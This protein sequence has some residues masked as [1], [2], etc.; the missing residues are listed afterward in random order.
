MKIISKILKKSLAAVFIAAM[1][2]VSF[3]SILIPKTEAANSYIDGNLLFIINSSNEAEIARSVSKGVSSI[4]IPNY[5]YSKSNKQYY[6]VTRIWDNAFSDCPEL[7][8]I[9]ISDSVTSIGSN[10]FYNTAYYNNYTNWENGVLYISKHLIKA[11]NGISGTYAIKSGTKCIAD[12]AFKDCT[13]LKYVV[14]PSSVTSIG[15]SA[16]SGCTGLTS[17]TIGNSVTSIGTSA[18]SGCTGLT[19]ITIPNSVTSIGTS[20]FY[21]CTGLTSITIGNSVTS[22]GTYAFY[23]CTGL[24]SITIPNS[25]T[26][27]GTSAFSGCTGLT[28]ITIPNSVTS[29]GS[30][31]FEGCTGLTSITIPDSVTRIEYDAFSGC[32]GLTS[33]TIPD[34]V[35]S[36]GYRV[37]DGC[38]IKELIIADGSKTVTS[39]MVV[40][41]S[42]LEKVTIPDSVMS[43]E[44]NA[45]KDCTGFTSITIPDSV[46]GIGSSAFEGCT[47]LASIAIP[48]SVTNIGSNAFYNTAYYNDDANWENDVLYISNHLIKA[49]DSINGVYAIKYGTKCIADSAFS[50]CTLLTGITIPDS[51]ASIGDNA[52]KGCTDLTSIIIPDKA[53][54]GSNAFY[55][56]PAY[57]TTGN[58]TWTLDGTVLTISGNGSMANY[59]YNEK[60]SWRQDITKV[61]IKSGVKNIGNYA[62]YGCK[63][64]TSVIVPESVTTIGFSSFL[65]CTGLTSIIIPSSVT[66]IDSS[67]FSGCDKSKLIIYTDSRDATAYKYAKDNGYRCVVLLN[68]NDEIGFSI[69]GNTLTVIGTGKTPDYNLFTSTPWYSAKDSITRVIVDSRITEVGTY[70]FYG[71]DNLKEL[72]CENANLKLG[73]RAINTDNKN[74]RV[75][76]LSGGSLEEYCSD[77]SVNFVSPL[78]APILVSVT[79]NSITVKA[80]D[81]VN[82]EFSLNGVNWQRSGQFNSLQPVTEYK[83]YS[84]R[85]NE[86]SPI[87]SEPLVV[88]TTKSTVSAPGAPTIEE[89]SVNKVTLKAT[90]GYEYSCDGGLT[91]QSSNVFEGIAQ[92]KIYEFRIRKAE[93]ETIFASKKSAALYFALPKAPEIERIGA[94]TLTLKA[95]DGFEYSLD[96]IEWQTSPHFTGLINN[97]T[98]TVY[99]RISGSQYSNSYQLISSGTDVCINGTDKTTPAKP[100]API[101]ASKTSSS[102]T[103]KA[104]EGYEY[105][106]DVKVWQISNVFNGLNDDTE[107]TFYQRVAETETS[108]ASECSA[109]LKVKTDKAYT[110]GEL[111]GDGKITDKD[112][113]YLLMHCYFPG[114]YPVDQPCDYNGDGIINDKDAVYLLMH[115]YFPNDYPITK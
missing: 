61:I 21:G 108:Y 13:E 24:T 28:S 84:R 22:I 97:M 7:A 102:V 110:A 32:T 95:V 78:D 115:C 76:S 5:V 56:C 80:A 53:T 52:F 26:S 14:V 83:V 10:A 64:L 101:V 49:K 113:I 6:R 16:F 48:D 67:A 23:G 37:F 44:D 19:S 96:K 31:A 59:K 79:G 2:V 39:T 91:W 51:V 20:A 70:S 12:A 11:G 1:I 73:T 3:G 105:S 68:N 88:K 90:S 81:G 60:A 54:I 45:F 63:E 35:T 25:V 82:A 36:I 111:D 106:L 15:T 42:T 112:A 46:T 55:G 34:S 69:D 40:C 50:D 8:N 89:Y 4:A 75:Y 41:K 87:A 72:V 29:I 33:I 65:N 30:S 74:I 43:I 104:T 66:S 27:I 114:D 107:Y 57:G 103:L 77:N 98:Y 71:F 9:T 47:G 62:F 38:N 18:F 86:Y 85:Y 92:N 99:Q 58:C 94:T 109:G 100:S 17:V 93:T